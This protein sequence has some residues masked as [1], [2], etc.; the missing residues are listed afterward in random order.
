M[1][2]ALMTILMLVSQISPAN[3]TQTYQLEFQHPRLGTWKK[4]VAAESSEIALEK[5]ALDCKSRYQSTRLMTEN[6][7][8]DIVDTCSRPK[9]KLI[10]AE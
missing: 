2:L 3:Q 10:R 5:S 9:I 7:I 6:E 8:L 1:K 4:S